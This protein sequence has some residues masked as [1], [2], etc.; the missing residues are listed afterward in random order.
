MATEKTDV[1]IVNVGAA[2]GGILAAGRETASG[3]DVATSAS[4]G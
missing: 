4:A 3:G 2:E 1:V